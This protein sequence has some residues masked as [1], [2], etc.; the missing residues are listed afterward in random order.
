MR[1][2]PI[3]RFTGGLRRGLRREAKALRPAEAL[4]LSPRPAR[5]W[6]GCRFSDSPE[7]G[8]SNNLITSTPTGS[9]DKTSRPD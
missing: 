9:S 2:R 3:L 7:A 1:S 5:P 4:S 8:L 6:T